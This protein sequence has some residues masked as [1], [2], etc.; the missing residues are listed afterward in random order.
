M[1]LSTTSRQKQ[2]PSSNR[3]L[4][5]VVSVFLWSNLIG[6]VSDPSIVSTTEI[7][8]VDGTPQFKVSDDLQ[9]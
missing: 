9:D 6:Q 3:V 1:M 8:L 4:A 7:Q 2:I 5:A